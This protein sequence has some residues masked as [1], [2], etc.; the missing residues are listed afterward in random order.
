[1]ERGPI[2]VMFVTSTQSN[3]KQDG[4]ISSSKVLVDPNDIFLSVAPHLRP[5][6]ATRGS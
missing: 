2:F 4:R 6:T 3:E 5:L 1:M